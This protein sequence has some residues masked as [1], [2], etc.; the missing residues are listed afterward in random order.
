[1][2]IA[3]PSPCMRAAL[4]GPCFKTGPYPSPTPGGRRKAAA[5]ARGSLRE[6]VGRT[7]RCRPTSPLVARS[8]FHPPL[9]C[10]TAGIPRVGPLDCQT[11]CWTTGSAV[12]GLSAGPGAGRPRITRHG[13]GAR[14][15]C[16]LDAQ[17]HPQ[18]TPAQTTARYSGPTAELRVRIH[19]TRLYGIL[20]PL[21]GCFSE[22]PHGTY[23]LSGSHFEI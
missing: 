20:A 9:P 5:L 3:V 1:M 11:Q 10:S 14:D 2:G 23:L 19:S 16:A 17:A 12:T 8:C 6:R 13:G 21:T 15:D 18:Q 4:L 7:L 22:F